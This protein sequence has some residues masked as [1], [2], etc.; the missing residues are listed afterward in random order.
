MSK[1]SDCHKVI[2][3]SSS[4]FLWKIFRFFFGCCMSDESLWEWERAPEPSDIYW[5]NLGTSTCARIFYSAAS[6]FS[7]AVLM[8]LCLVMIASIKA[9]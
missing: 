8:G 5:E 1:P 9:W 6:Y 7:T 3:K 4:G 2:K